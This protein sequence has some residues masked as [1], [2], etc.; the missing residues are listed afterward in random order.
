MV[1]TDAPGAERLRGIAEEIV[2]L[3]EADAFTVPILHSISVQMLAYEVTLLKGT[4]V[5]QP[6]N[7]VSR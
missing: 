6:R 7:L 2:V 3:P 4:D 1:F 5:D